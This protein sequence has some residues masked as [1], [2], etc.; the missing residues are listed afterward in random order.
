[1]KEVKAM[2]F[3]DCHAS[4]GP[5]KTLLEL[6]VPK[7]LVAQMERV[8]ISRALVYHGAAVDGYPLE[9]NERLIAELE[10]YPQLVPAR[11]LLPPQTGEW[12]LESFPSKMKKCKVRALWAFP[13]EHNYLLNKVAMGPVLEEMV[14]RTIPLFVKA[15][16][17]W[18]LIYSLLA[19]FPQL[20]L[21]AAGHGPW[22]RDRYFRP[23]LERYPN[24]YIDTANYELDWGL[25]FLCSKYGHERILFGTN[26]PHRAAGGPLLTLLHAPISDAAKRAI[27]AGNLERLLGEVKL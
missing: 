16:G 26:T 14:A 18:E 10:S 23:L 2:N 21:V 25:A 20:T 17:N 1:M 6:P 5:T 3:F 24:F 7:A 8:G 15:E 22:G 27:A 4:Y 13:K 9:A 19:D 12:D 11:V